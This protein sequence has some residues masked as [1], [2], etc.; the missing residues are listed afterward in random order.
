MFQSS[1]PT[2]DDE[3]EPRFTAQSLM[4]I[5]AQLSGALTA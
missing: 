4:L 1:A 5:E 2:P 3:T